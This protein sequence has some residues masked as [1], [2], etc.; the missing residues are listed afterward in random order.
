M[1]R[2]VI[3]VG[4]LLVAHIASAAEPYN[5]PR[6]AQPSAKA[7]GFTFIE[8][9]P[10][11]LVVKQ[12]KEQGKSHFE[13]EYTEIL[14]VAGQSFCPANAFGRV[15]PVIEYSTFTTAFGDRG[16]NVKL[17][18]GVTFGVHYRTLR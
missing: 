10:D 13:A 9:C 7:V 15:Y 3:T 16:H 5:P 1:K 18:Q 4:L 17:G 8:S 6:R 12:I 2:F 14:Q 11:E